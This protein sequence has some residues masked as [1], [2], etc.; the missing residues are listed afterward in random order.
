MYLSL[1][2]FRE[3]PFSLFPDHRFLFLNRRYKLALSLLE[4]GILNQNGMILL[5]GDPGT[6]KT[7]L[8]QKILST[9]ED[10][11][12]IGKL[13]FTHD[14]SESLLPW[15]LQAYGLSCPGTHSADRF[16]AIAEFFARTYQEGKGILLVV[17]EAQNLEAEKLE[18]LRLVFNLNDREGPV[19][20]VLLAGHTQLREQLK[21]PRLNAFTQRI[22]TDFNLETFDSHDTR[23][24]IHHRLEA[25]GG[26][27]A[28]YSDQACEMVYRCT[29]G[30]PR[31]INQ[32]CEMSLVYGFSEQASSI[33]KSLIIEAAKDREDSGLFT[34][35]PDEMLPS[36]VEEGEELALLRNEVKTVPDLTKS[37]TQDSVKVTS[38]PQGHWDQA[39]HFKQEGWYL[40]AIQHFKYAVSHPT[41]YGPGWFQVGLCYAALNRH[42]TALEAFRVALA[43][44]G[45][46]DTE[47][48]SVQQATGQVLEQM[49][50]TDQ[51]NRYYDMVRASD[52]SL[53][54]RS[55]N[56]FSSQD[57]RE[58]RGVAIPE[59]NNSSWITRLFRRW[60]PQS[61]EN[62]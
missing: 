28:L 25:V 12:T 32:L 46:S 39:H 33:T 47:R 48:I 6:G 55:Y 27:P 16:Q 44:P 15:I 5:T 49:G 20:Q 61:K 22:G 57:G 2:G 29:G 42:K 30:N 11:L 59:V 54:P 45:I 10:T 34:L 14:K 36:R 17:D 43:S 60:W 23:A 53:D 18:E 8:L 21:D 41:Y 62:S 38:D 19:F 13:T 9:A 40:E 50:E 3:K 26:S 37:Q 51:A 7:T 35:P 52:S 58:Q 4:F 1:Y 31:L 56:V 24:Y